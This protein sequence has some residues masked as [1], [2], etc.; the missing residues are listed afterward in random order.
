MTETLHDL[1][2]WLCRQLQSEYDHLTSDKS[3]ENGITANEYTF[4]AGVRLFG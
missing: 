4:T 3:V 2:R 1:D